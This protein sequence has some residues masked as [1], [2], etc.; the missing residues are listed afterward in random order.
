MQ[1]ADPATKQRRMVKPQALTSRILGPNGD[2]I[3]A[4]MHAARDYLDSHTTAELLERVGQHI[5]EIPPVKPVNKTALQDSYGGSQTAPKRQTRLVPYLWPSRAI[6]GLREEALLCPE[7]GKGGQS[8]RN[9]ELTKAR[10]TSAVMAVGLQRSVPVTGGARRCTDVSAQT[11]LRSCQKHSD[12]MLPADGRLIVSA[13]VKEWLE[14]VPVQSE[15]EK[16]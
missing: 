3:A 2:G 6:Q 14:G 10:S 13:F 16:A 9:G 15:E 7:I 5:K 8:W 1:A 12:G 4:A 11:P